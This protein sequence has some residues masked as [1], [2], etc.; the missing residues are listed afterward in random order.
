MK[1]KILLAAALA[2]SMAACTQDD[3]TE[4]L[5]GKPVTITAG[6]NQ[7]ADT[8]VD[9]NVGETSTQ[10]LW[11]EGDTFS[12]HYE[13]AA[14]ALYEFALDPNDA[15]K[16]SGAF[17]C[18][19]LPAGD[20]PTKA[21]HACYYG[22]SVTYADVKT[23][24]AAFYLQDGT[25]VSS[26][27]MGATVD[28]T[29]GNIKEWKDLDF[30]FENKTAMLELTL[31]NPAFDKAFISNITLTAPGLVSSA[32]Y[33]FATGEWT[34]PSIGTTIK[35]SD[36]SY[37]TG[38]EFTI[39]VAQPVLP[40]VAT[41]PITI[42]ATAGGTDY[43][44]ILKSGKFGAAKMYI[45]EAT[46][47]E[48]DKTMAFTVV[49]D[50]T[51]KE[52]TLPF[53]GTSGDYTLTVNWGDGTISTI[54]PRT[55]AEVTTTAH[56]YA[57]AGTYTVNLT[58]TAASTAVQMPKWD[59]SVGADIGAMLKS[60]DTPMLKM[61]ADDFFYLFSECKKLETIPA[62]LFAKNKTATSFNMCFYSCT[63]LKEIPNGLFHGLDDVTSFAGCFYGCTAAKANPYIFW[64]EGTDLTTYFASRTIGFSNCFYNVGSNLQSGY[65]GV[66]PALWN[67]TFAG[68]TKTNCFDGCENMT[69]FA[70]I[71]DDWK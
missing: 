45:A 52:I 63:A 65:A 53:T 39:Y 59:L 16:T 32:K 27:F 15:G 66:P 30:N 46:M 64:P 42:T 13:G 7:K 19:N 20:V 47:T 10:V 24:L 37:N 71:P 68:V 35:I 58:S 21:I 70:D 44:A 5:A 14:S 31:K 2:I 54:D 56:T 55:N 11:K 51:N 49:A 61:N 8:R 40:D 3:N 22:G 38:E 4:A 67:C 28:N 41:G 62:D 48:A 12:I 17:T 43:T 18:Q 6:I 60:M 33:T 23:Y 25:G 57:A 9:F 26:H 50:E 36:I 1:A 29:S 34:N 69:N